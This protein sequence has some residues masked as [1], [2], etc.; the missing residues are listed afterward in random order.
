MTEPSSSRMVSH[1]RTNKWR[2]S[3]SQGLCRP[4]PNRR[5]HRDVLLG[6]LADGPRDEVVAL[7]DQV[8]AGVDEGHYAPVVEVLDEVHPRLEQ[9]RATERD[10]LAS[11]PDPRP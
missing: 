6:L 11:H 2:R 4:C 8:A 10:T 5:Q 1:R 7:A 9:L 3:E